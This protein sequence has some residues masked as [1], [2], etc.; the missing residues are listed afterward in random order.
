MIFCNCWYCDDQNRVVQLPWVILSRTCFSWAMAMAL[1]SIFPLPNIVWMFLERLISLFKNVEDDPNLSSRMSKM[2]RL[3]Q[4][5]GSHITAENSGSISTFRT[6]CNVSPNSFAWYCPSHA[7]P[8]HDDFRSNSV[9]SGVSS[10]N[11]C[12]MVSTIW[13][14]SSP[15]VA[16]LTLPTSS[17]F[18]EE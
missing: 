15:A 12:F 2:A 8:C 4:W 3:I 14:A 7:V 13:F 1:L 5:D 18:F 6:S 16:P 9:E 17:L 10:S 11:A